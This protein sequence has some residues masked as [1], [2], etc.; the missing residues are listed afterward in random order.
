MKILLDTHILIWH[1][2]RDPKLSEQ[3]VKMIYDP[4]NDIFVSMASFY[5][6][7]IKMKIGKL[8][9]NSSL[10]QFYEDTI[11]DL[12]AVLPISEQYLSAYHNI[13]LLEEHRDPFDRL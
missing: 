1:S 11:N 12:I 13:P 4:G 7:A 2:Q 6:I 3:A 9:I 10:H 5:E 8:E